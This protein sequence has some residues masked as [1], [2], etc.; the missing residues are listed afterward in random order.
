MRNADAAD[1]A[2]RAWTT[3]EAERTRYEATRKQPNRP[4]SVSL[5]CS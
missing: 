2:V 3:E 4:A 1:R 5:L